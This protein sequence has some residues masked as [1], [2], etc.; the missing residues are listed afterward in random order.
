M[1]IKDRRRWPSRYIPRAD[2]TIG[3]EVGIMSTAPEGGAVT[4]GLSGA[5]RRLLGNLHEFCPEEE[6]FSVYLE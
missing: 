4:T 3:D 1:Y 6:A 2:L 5:G